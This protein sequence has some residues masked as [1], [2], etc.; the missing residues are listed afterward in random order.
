MREREKF[1][2]KVN[3][4]AEG[5]QKMEETLKSK[6][7]KQSKVSREYNSLF[8]FTS[9]SKNGIDVLQVLMLGAHPS[10]ICTHLIAPYFFG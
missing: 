7:G 9:D 5:N 1:K 3:S 2:D 8:I 4:Q 6:H 10:E